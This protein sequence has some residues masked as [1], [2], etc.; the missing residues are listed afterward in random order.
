M[1]RSSFIPDKEAQMSVSTK[2]SIDARRK[3]KILYN[4]VVS[5]LPE[6]AQRV[7]EG[8]KA[9]F[10]EKRLCSSFNRYDP[11]GCWSFKINRICIL[12]E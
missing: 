1:V 9:I 2:T 11:T 12:P 4:D 8:A 5:S 6:K 3:N 7:L 10:L